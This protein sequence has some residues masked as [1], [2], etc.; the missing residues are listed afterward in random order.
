M[1]RPSPLG[2]IEK[3]IE[4]LS[5]KDQL[6]LVEKLAH[7]LTKTGIAARKELDWKRLY[8]LGKGLWKGE[9][10]QAYVNRLREDRM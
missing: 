4:R 5:P 7:Q 3:E 1:P 6:K 8:G 2:K 9:D 10:A